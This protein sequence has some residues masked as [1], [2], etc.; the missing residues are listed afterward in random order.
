M[1]KKRELLLF[2]NYSRFCRA[3]PSPIPQ[4]KQTWTSAG[5]KL[6]RKR[7]L[8]GRAE[9]P[10]LLPQGVLGAAASGCPAPKPPAALRL[11]TAGMVPAHPQL[12]MERTL[13]QRGEQ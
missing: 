5:A 8:Q 3:H 9:N 12:A 10:V 11:S 7:E 4:R 1:P 6:S 2:Y 13:L